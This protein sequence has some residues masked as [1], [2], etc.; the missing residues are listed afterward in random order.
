MNFV[1]TLVRAATLVLLFADPALSAS[2][3]QK[4]CKGPVTGTGLHAQKHIAVSK[5]RVDWSTKVKAM[6]GPGWTGPGQMKIHGASCLPHRGP[7]AGQNFWT[8]QFVASPCKVV[9]S[10]LSPFAPGVKPR[11]GLPGASLRRR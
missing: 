11:V 9:N 10:Q 5:A 6:Y 1:I 7:K 3:S 2:Y 8:C 4:H